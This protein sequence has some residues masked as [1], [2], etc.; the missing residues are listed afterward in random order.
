MKLM[1]SPAPKPL[2]AKLVDIHCADVTV[3]EA[4][5]CTGGQQHCAARGNIREEAPALAPAS[6]Y[7]H[8][9]GFPSLVR[10]KSLRPTTRS[11][12]RGTHRV[13]D[14]AAQSNPPIAA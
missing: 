14:Y 13:S 1:L 6:H 7:L 5:M 2:L 10:C 3:V 11:L 12:C 4:T 9:R 8:F